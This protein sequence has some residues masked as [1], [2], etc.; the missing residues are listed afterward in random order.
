MPI[1][2]EITVQG[3][4]GPQRAMESSAHGKSGT[5]RSGCT[6]RVCGEVTAGL[7]SRRNFCQIKQIWGGRARGEK[8]TARVKGQKCPAVGVR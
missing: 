5:N 7:A 1:K 4:K 8:E 2:R 6:E 3:G